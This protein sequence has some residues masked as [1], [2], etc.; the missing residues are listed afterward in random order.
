[1]TLPGTNAVRLSII[2]P[3][4]RRAGKLERLLLSLEPQ[5]A[6][7]SDRE[8]IVV[9]DASDDP[10]Y[11]SLLRRFG[12]MLQLLT[13]PQNT[14]PSAARNTGSRA[15]HGEF[16][17]FTDDDCVA[18]PFW[19]D[20]LDNIL[21][22]NPDID[23]IGGEA[24]P[25]PHERG[26]T[27]TRWVPDGFLRLRTW[28]YRDVVTLCSSCILAVRRR[29]F[30]R[31]GGFREA[32]RWAE[33]RNLT[34]RLRQ[35]GAIIYTDHAWHMYHESEANLRQ[36]LRRRI[37]YGRGAFEQ[38]V[39][40]QPAIDRAE[41][42]DEG[43]FALSLG[44]RIGA[45]TRRLA[46]YRQHAG[47]ERKWWPGYVAMAALTPLAMDWGYL[48][49]RQKHNRRKTGLGPTGH[50]C[51]VS[52]G[53]SGS[54]VLGDMLSQCPAL[55]WEQEI[56]THAELRGTAPVSYDLLPQRVAHHANRSFGFA[57]HP[58]HVAG[59][60]L[61]MED[62]IDRATGDG[63]A[64]FILLVRRNSLRRHLS[65]R[66]ARQTGHFHEFRSDFWNATPA[67]RIHLE[68]AGKAGRDLLAYFD[69]LEADYAALRSLLTP[70]CFIELSY[71][72]DIEPDPT[73]GLRKVAAFLD[74]PDFDPVVRYQRF[75]AHKLTDIVANYA[76]VAERIGASKHA[77][78]LDG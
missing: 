35:A 62:F 10:S 20:W 12:S 4:F 1:M 55:A 53:R 7:R 67:K 21:I 30:E 17:V 34:Y 31:I 77:W 47:K 8:L 75:N 45:E 54:T 52:N 18:T 74:L 25:L 64:N 28:S 3:T 5:L 72:A 58:A 40:E 24:R 43:A 22:E 32:A 70:H 38:M 69:R 27:V 63:V 6:G 61:S 39:R 68:V 36:H 51:L 66:A 46:N 42:P 60:G 73:I 9:D 59:L 48:R 57:I 44:R 23:L 37:G 19:L 26:L 49:A 76:E 41:W 71:E 65:M 29:W 16:L 14:G 11:A 56:Y 78:M 33:D 50:S 2:V 15:S 13:H